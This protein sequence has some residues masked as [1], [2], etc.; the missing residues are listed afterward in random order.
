MIENLSTSQIEFE[1]KILPLLQRFCCS[2][3]ILFALNEDSEG[4]DSNETEDEGAG[5]MNPY[6]ADLGDLQFG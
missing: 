6:L 5:E 2:F 3:C 4:E 1:K